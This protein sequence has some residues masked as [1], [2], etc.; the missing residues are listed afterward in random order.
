MH[1]HSVIEQYVSTSIELNASDL[2][3]K[4]NLSPM[5]RKSAKLVKLSSDIVTREVIIDFLEKFTDIDEDKF[6]KGESA[7]D[8]S[9]TLCVVRLR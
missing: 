9:I 2:H 5:I 8:F 3:L 7:F 1:A 6:V 4:T